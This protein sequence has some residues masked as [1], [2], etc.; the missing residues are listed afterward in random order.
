[1]E[2][3]T[4]RTFLRREGKRRAVRRRKATGKLLHAE[5]RGKADIVGS[6]RRREKCSG[7][8]REKMSCYDQRAKPERK[9]KNRA[10][11]AAAL[12]QPAYT[13]AS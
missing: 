12:I 1:V 2:I 11:R 3:K 9:G 6:P 8:E 10:S 5:G 13:L 4:D 7:C